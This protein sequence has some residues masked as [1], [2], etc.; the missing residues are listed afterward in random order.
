MEGTLIDEGFIYIEDRRPEAERR[1]EYKG[2]LKRV[3][4]LPL[5]KQEDT[6][7]K[8]NQKIDSSIVALTYYQSEENYVFLFCYGNHH[9]FFAKKKITE[10]FEL[11]QDSEV[12]D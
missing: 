11:G 12:K 6:D 8:K 9:W 2:R 1:A 7:G 3:Q 5:L 4:I 10:I